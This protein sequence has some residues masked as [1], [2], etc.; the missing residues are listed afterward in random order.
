MEKEAVVAK[1]EY[2]ERQGTKREKGRKGA[3][4][5]YEIFCTKEAEVGLREKK[6]TTQTWVSLPPPWGEIKVKIEHLK[7]KIISHGNCT[8]CWV[9]NFHA[10]TQCNP[11]TH[12]ASTVPAYGMYTHAA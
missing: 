8:P 2:G 12:V 1:H 10:G 4:N 11:H 7:S 9:Y 5:M 6:G 3:L